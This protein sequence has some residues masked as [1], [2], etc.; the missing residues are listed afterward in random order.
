MFSQSVACGYWIGRIQQ[1]NQSIPARKELIGM[2][3][4]LSQKKQSE[5]K[6]TF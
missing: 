5:G 4:M 3:S 1:C 2:K 6:I